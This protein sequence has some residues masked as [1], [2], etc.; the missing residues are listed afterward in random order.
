MIRYGMKDGM[1]VIFVNAVPMGKIYRA[2]YE[3]GPSYIYSHKCTEN[4][5]YR[6][7]K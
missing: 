3:E 2:H 5:I 6:I 1:K 7:K 4:L